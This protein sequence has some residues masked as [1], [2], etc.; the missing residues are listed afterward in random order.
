MDKIKAELTAITE[1]YK[2][3]VRE[4]W[5]R[6]NEPDSL[7]LNYELMKMS[8]SNLKSE[9]LENGGKYSNILDRNESHEIKEVIRTLLVDFDEFLSVVS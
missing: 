5:N 4:N 6:K 9:L 8:Q 2:K 7:G 1:K 3:L